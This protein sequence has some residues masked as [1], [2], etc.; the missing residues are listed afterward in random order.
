M[1]EANTNITSPEV[2]WGRVEYT[3]VII[4]EESGHVHGARIKRNRDAV[5]RDVI[6]ARDPDDDDANNLKFEQV[7]QGVTLRSLCPTLP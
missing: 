6:A 1:K 3:V 5:V 4:F 7:N 2:F